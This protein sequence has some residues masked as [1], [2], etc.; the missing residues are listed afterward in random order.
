MRGKER[1]QT[2]KKG[3]NKHKRKE[4]TKEREGWWREALVALARL[5]PEKP[6]VKWEGEKG[7]RRK[8]IRSDEHYRDVVPMHERSMCSLLYD[9]KA[10]S[11]T[12][13]PITG[14][15][16]YINPSPRQGGPIYS[17]FWN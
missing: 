9:K 15:V 12:L 7:V 14:K 6:D 10:C 11:S 8:E 17:L 1:E 5:W 13:R 4:R 2:T 16:C 3:T